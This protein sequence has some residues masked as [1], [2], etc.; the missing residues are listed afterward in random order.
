MG[1]YTG[2]PEIETQTGTH[3]RR[4]YPVVN[5]S[6]TLRS[7]IGL[8]WAGGVCTP[9]NCRNPDGEYAP[10]KVAETPALPF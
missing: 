6:S 9:V 2:V 8:S 5:K 4:D 7:K 10:G 3:S 1:G